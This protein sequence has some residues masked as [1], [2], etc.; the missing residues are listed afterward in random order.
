MDPPGFPSYF[1]RS[2]YTSHGNDPHRGIT[3][4]IT[5]PDGKDHPVRRAGDPWDDDRK[6]L[7]SLWVPLPLDHPR[8]RLWVRALYGYM[9]HC[10]RDVERPEY[11]RPGTLIYPVPY[12]AKVEFNDDP[13][14]S[15][16]WRTAEKANMARANAELDERAKRIATP[17][18]HNAVVTIRRFYPNYQPETD[19]IANPP[20]WG[21][22]GLGDWWQTEA[23]AP[24]PENCRPR[25]LDRPH[26]VNVDWC[27]WCGWVDPARKE[28]ASA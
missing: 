8:T 7:R 14:F 28:E 1:V 12:W 17:E 4:V 27:Q 9:A 3:Q 13:R 21:A 24:T 22:G 19:L 6:V 15:D 23:E 18:N 20:V 11:N 10:Y 25:D 5:G 16:A 26:P 2:V